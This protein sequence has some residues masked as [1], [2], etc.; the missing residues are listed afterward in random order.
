M[1][2]T[3]PPDT[4]RRSESS[5]G[6]LRSAGHWWMNSPLTLWV[7]ITVLVLIVIAAALVVV[8][9]SGD[10]RPGARPAAPTPAPATEHPGG[11]GFGPPTADAL[12]RPVTTPHNPDG[13]ALPQQPVARGPYTAGEQ[14]PAPE[15]LEWQRTSGAVL[16]FSTSD[17]PGRITGELPYDFART[18]QGAALAGYQLPMRGLVDDRTYRNITENLAVR[19]PE[20]DAALADLEPFDAREIAVAA[21]RPAAFRITGWIEGEF[22]AIQYALPAGRHGPY[23]VTNSEVVWQDG[24]WKIRDAAAMAVGEKNITT[25]AGWTLW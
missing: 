24:Q 11:E 17:G 5:P 19:T 14:L 8:S 3:S 23:R 16:P 12:G 21:P 18:P 10:D 7:S 6:R 9:T 15:G 25:L 2:E 1:T 20:V 13:Q 22:A 4:D